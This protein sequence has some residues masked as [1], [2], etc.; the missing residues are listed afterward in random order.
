MMIFLD[1][2]NLYKLFNAKVSRD[3]VLRSVKLKEFNESQLE[4][5]IDQLDKKFIPEITKLKER[6]ELD[7]FNELEEL[8]KSIRRYNTY[9]DCLLENIGEEYLDM[10]MTRDII[11][12]DLKKLKTKIDLSDFEKALKPADEKVKSNAKEI[13]KKFS[14]LS[15]DPN[16]PNQYWWR[17]LDRIES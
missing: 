13:I 1:T 14:S 5:E 12:E 17:H 8:F 4:K 7:L 15:K 10:I 2:G 11:H 3:S 6:I 16:A 9:S